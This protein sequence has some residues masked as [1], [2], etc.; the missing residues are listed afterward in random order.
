MDRFRRLQTPVAAPA[1][2]LGLM[3]AVAVALFLAAA[4]RGVASRSPGGPGR[5]A[6]PD[7]AARSIA[8]SNN[9]FGVDL[10]RQLRGA[11][12]NLFFSPYSI[13]SALAM[14]WAGAR[15]STESEMARTL[16]FTM[17]QD[18][19]HAA[20]HALRTRLEDAAASGRYELA[21]ANRLWGRQGQDFLAPF[22]ETTRV[23]Y[24][25]AL[26]RLDFAGAP[27]ASR[28]TINRWV[29]GKTKG[30]IIDLLP[31]GSITDL[32][33]LV[34]TNAIYFKGRWPEPFRKD[35][36]SDAVF[37][38]DPARD[39]RAPMM[40]RSGRMLIAKLQGLK[41]LVLKYEGKDLS[42]AIL[43]PNRVDGLADLEERLDADSLARWIDGA[44]LEEVRISMPRFHT[45]SEFMLQDP[46]AAMGMPSA[47]DPKTADLSGTDGARDL[48]ISA[49][50]HKAFVDVGEEG[51][52]AAASTGVV[53]GLSEA[54]PLEPIPFIADHP[55]LFLIRDDASGAILFLG[56]LSN[57]LL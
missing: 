37:H 38:L 6:P 31:P 23:S 15:G 57:P 12:G 39:V 52:E 44:R 48:F 5:A 18:S 25:A 22:L 42:M 17:P 11:E 14:T 41:V 35:R 47:F 36:T 34:L 50:V 54:R 7:P 8:R 45:T 53:E 10:Y 46:L 27:E 33:S 20:M 13:S 56:R 29:E 1:R 21:I 55:F 16:L 49:V 3:L 4:A 19:V 26:E 2:A 51:T 40:N 24:G 43:L 9:R 32:T 30:R 28:T